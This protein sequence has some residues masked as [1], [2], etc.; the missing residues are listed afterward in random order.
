M[1]VEKHEVGQSRH[2]YQLDFNN[3]IESF[4]FQAGGTFIK[5]LTQRIY[6]K[7][8]T[9]KHDCIEGNSQRFTQCMNNYIMKRL[10][11]VLPWVEMG[12]NGIAKGIF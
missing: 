2:N 3:G 4:S 11:C 5:T 6:E 8:K 9:K 1:S 10:N 7:V 12:G